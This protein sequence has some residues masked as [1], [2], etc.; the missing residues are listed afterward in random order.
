[1][2]TNTTEIAYRTAG[3]AT[4]RTTVWANSIISASL[5]NAYTDT[6][7]EAMVQVRAWKEKG[8]KS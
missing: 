4:I 2:T 5:F 1:M 6:L 8:E 7:S 3:S